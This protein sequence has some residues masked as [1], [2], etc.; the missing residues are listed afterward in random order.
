LQVLRFFPTKK[1]DENYENLQKEYPQFKIVQQEIL[2]G[3]Q[4]MAPLLDKAEKFIDKFDKY[5]KNKA[6]SQ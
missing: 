5:K 1:F 3:V 4:K 6:L 2:D